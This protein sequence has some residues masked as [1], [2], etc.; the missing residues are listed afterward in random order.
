MGDTFWLHWTRGGVTSS[1]RGGKIYWNE[2]GSDP[3]DSLHIVAN[4]LL[5]VSLKIAA[6][7]SLYIFVW[8]FF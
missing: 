3:Q 2:L 7:E 4:N 1:F 8:R 6:Q 5:L